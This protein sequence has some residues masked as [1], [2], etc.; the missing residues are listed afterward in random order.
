MLIEM[1]RRDV[2]FCDEIDKRIFRYLYKVGQI[3]I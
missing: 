2:Y 3:R 1:V